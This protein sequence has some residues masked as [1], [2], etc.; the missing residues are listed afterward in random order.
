MDTIIL[1]EQKLSILVKKAV[2]EAMQ[3]I[4]FDED[5]GSRL[6]RQFVKKLQQSIVSKKA[7]HFASLENVVKKYQK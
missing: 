2:A 5:R 4:L 1:Q 7:G 3:D 6:Q